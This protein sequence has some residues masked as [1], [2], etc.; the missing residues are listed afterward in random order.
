MPNLQLPR[1][2]YMHSERIMHVDQAIFVTELR[3]RLGEQ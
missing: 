3:H 2:Q 1:A